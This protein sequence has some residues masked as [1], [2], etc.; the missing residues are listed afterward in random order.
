MSNFIVHL[1][2]KNVH[3]LWHVGYMKCVLFFVSVILNQR[4]RQTKKSLLV[5][6]TFVYILL[7]SK[8][9]ILYPRTTRKAAHFSY[10]RSD[11]RAKNETREV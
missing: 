10:V 9:Y 8:K 11:A 5:C 3:N 1:V 7:S 4:R 6:P 2:N